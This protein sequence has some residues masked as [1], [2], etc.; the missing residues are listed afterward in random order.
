MSEVSNGKDQALYDLAQQLLRGEDVALPAKVQNRLIAAMLVDNR[1]AQRRDMQEVM[2]NPAVKVGKFYQE[3]KT[4]SKVIGVMFFVI[5]NMWF[6]A[7]FRIV[8]ILALGE[9]F[10]IPQPIIDFLTLGG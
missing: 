7:P 3:N 6:V 5:A 4:I 10:K 1:K 8:T 2:N 9:W